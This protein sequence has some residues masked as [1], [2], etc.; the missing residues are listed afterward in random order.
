MTGGT[1]DEAVSVIVGTLLLILITVTAAAGLA[2]MVS[3]MQKDEMNRQSHLAAVKSEN[4]QVLDIGLAN[5][6][7]AWNQSPWNITADQSWSNWSSV[8]F[9][10]ANLNTDDT[11]IIGIAVNDHYSRTITAVED[12]AAAGRTG[13][14]ISNADYLTLAGTRG[15][16]VQI[17]FTDDFP[18]TQYI[19]AGTP[20]RVRVMT[21]LY[22]TFEMTFKPPNPVITT[23]IDTED[24]G[25]TARDVIVLDGSQSTADRTV[26][27]WDWMVLDR[28]NATPVNGDYWNDAAN[29]TTV[30]GK[31]VRLNPGTPGPFSIK[32]KVTDDTG[33][34][35]VSG[36]TEIPAN[37]RFVPPSNLNAGFNATLSQIQ[38]SVRDINGNPLSGITVNFVI[39]NN[40]YGNLTLGR[41]YDIT[42]ASGTASADCTAGLGTVK[43]ISGKLSPV[44]IPVAAA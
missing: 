16:K 27:Q 6:R 2:I 36:A 8:T 24:L 11:R 13:Y 31:L 23:H 18:S 41:Y 35:Q 17:N 40:P 38:A 26:V 1:N 12:T 39:T 5:D 22:N 34:A 21:S 30:S 10:L 19:P 44:E 7:A 25:V 32:L 28:G 43:I 37:T 4:I 14:N 20:I 29:I 42:D 33:M 9:T 15:Q 3:Q